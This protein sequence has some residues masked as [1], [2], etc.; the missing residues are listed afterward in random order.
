MDE[1]L[2]HHEVR[3]FLA[4][5]AIAAYSMSAHDVASV[6]PWTRHE[7][8][9][10]DLDVFNAALATLETRAHL[11]LLVARGTVL[12]TEVDGVVL[13][14]VRETAGGLRIGR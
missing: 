4:V 8:A 7:H 10:K 9:L 5:A 1:L 2:A 14:S 3:L 11:E 6:L 13:Y 12:R